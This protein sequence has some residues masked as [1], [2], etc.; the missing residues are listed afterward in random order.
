MCN[1]NNRFRSTRNGST[2]ICEGCGKR[3]RETG[4]EESNFGLCALCLC[5]A[6]TENFIYDNV[7]DGEVRETML[8]EVSN[9]ATVEECQ[10]IY[11]RAKELNVA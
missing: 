3:T 6:E 1:K 9:A 10:E 4:R 8:R 11:K 5:R 7:R 2:Y